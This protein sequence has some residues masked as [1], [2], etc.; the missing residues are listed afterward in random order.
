MVLVFDG[1]ARAQGK[2][3][4]RPV[5]QAG[6]L[7]PPTQVHAD[8][9][10]SDIAFRV[11]ADHIRCLSF[12]IAD[13]ILPS[14]EGRGYVLRRILRRAVRYGRNL[15]FHEPFFY[16]LV[17]VVADNFGG[18]FPEVRRR[19]KKIESTL[20]A[21][22]E[23]F[24]R[25]LD[26]GILLFDSEVLRN[27]IQAAAPKFGYS[28][29]E[30]GHVI[31]QD[32]LPVDQPDSLWL[33]KDGRRI[34][35]SME[36]VRSG[37][38]KEYI[39]E[40]EILA[41][42]A[43]KLYDTYGFPL[44]LTELMARERGL[45]V[46]VAGFEKLME[47]QRQR[48]RED[49]AKK[50]TVVTVVGEG[51]QVEP[52]KFLGYD[53]L[54]AEAVVEAVAP[55]AKLEFELILDKTPFYAEMGGQVGDTGLVHVPGHDRTEIGKLQVLDTQK[56]GEVF[57]HRARLTSGRAPEVGE[58]V[59]V[60]V[61]AARRANIQRHHTATHLFHWA[62][63]EVV[64]RD[65]RQRGSLVAPDRF[66]FD[67]NYPE[68]LS[69]AQIA[70]IERLVNE[71]I[72]ENEPVFWKEMPYAKVQKNACIQ[73]F[74]GEK[75]GDVVRVLQVGGHA[76]KFDGFSME[77]CGGTHVRQHGRHRSVQDHA[78]VGHCRG[79]PSRRG[80]VRTVCAGIHRE[81]E[82]AGAGRSGEGEGARG[83]ERGRAKTES[84]K[85]KARTGDC[86][87]A[88]GANPEAGWRQPRHWQSWRGQRGPAATR[89]R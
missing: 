53:N 15:G 49:H 17:G 40:A 26:R 31:I 8:Q 34:V 28:V 16:K 57:V 80:G 87:E 35:M 2:L 82:I 74:F 20:K 42:D 61:D 69:D 33:S 44:D 51:L 18:V 64:S 23:G 24:N 73:Q 85:R 22:E 65:A 59:R 7:A 60:A 62:L 72:K 11:I 1:A 79:Y 77:L 56:Q 21:E 83:R 63:H 9:V 71:R 84:G 13:G 47:E 14:N 38:M 30:S 10:K 19:R 89:H 86:G 37:A 67:F 81:G 3:A 58:A 52:T 45:T 25:T 6:T 48:A 76:G 78:R 27:A 66:R 29:G 12:A 70:D 68:K 50:K 88:S 32:G 36:E 43:F 75:Y 39:P 55:A 4:S 46:D 5:A 54:E 41:K